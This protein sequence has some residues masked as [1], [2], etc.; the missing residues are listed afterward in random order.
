MIDAETMRG[1]GAN[2]S[3]ADLRMR[4]LWLIAAELAERLDAQNAKLDA[5][6]ERLDRIAEA[7]EGQDG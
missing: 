2:W 5:V 4:D 3:Q 7:V 1:L 6:L